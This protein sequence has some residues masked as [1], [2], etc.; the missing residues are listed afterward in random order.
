MKATELRIGNLLKVGEF[1]WHVDSI[2][3]NGQFE[4]YFKENDNY[5]HWLNAEPIP[6]T[7]EWLFALGFNVFESMSDGSETI[8]KEDL[9]YRVSYYKT[10]FFFGMSYDDYNVTLLY[11]HQLQ[12][13]YFALTG[14]ELTVK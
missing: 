11:V 9:G 10:N 7:K 6:L 8:Y 13:L 12:N 3:N 4:V 1:Y 5:S 2:V 14:E